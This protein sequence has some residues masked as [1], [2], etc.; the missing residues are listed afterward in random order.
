[1]LQIFDA[2]NGD[3]SCVR[4]ARS[5]TPLEALATLNETL[6]LESARALALRTLREGGVNDAERLTYAFR[7][8]VARKPSEGE[9]AELK[10]LLEKE[11]RRFESGEL[12][13]LDLVADDPAQ[14]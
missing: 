6:F 10:N 13:P 12:N 7:L 5:D 2:P 4:R 8:C 14:P 1:M 9:S 11:T 3:S